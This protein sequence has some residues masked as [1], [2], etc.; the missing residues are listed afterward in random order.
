[1]GRRPAIAP[2][3]LEKLVSDRYLLFMTTATADPEMIA[4]LL[5]HLGRLARGEGTAAR[6]TPAQWAC[7]RFF[8]RANNST[9]TPSGFAGF[10]ATTRG[11]ASQIIKSLEGRGLLVRRRSEQDRR[12]VRFDLTDS[13]AAMLDQDP[14]G[15]LMGVI[16]TLEATEQARFR[17]TLTR[18]AAALALHRDVPA[19]GSCRDCGHFSD[20]GGRAHCACMAADLGRTE[21]DRLCA[22][23][24]AENGDVT[25]PEGD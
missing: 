23:F 20:T 6:L 15:D 21:I 13:G 12:S 3:G 8:A 19:F 11:T 2:R 22:S 7:L 17:A 18:V 9:R 1:M 4:E 5:V 14:L 25:P 10:Q 16:G 24:A